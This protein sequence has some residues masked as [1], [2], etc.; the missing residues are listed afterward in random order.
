MRLAVLA[1]AGEKEDDKFAAT[2]S[3]ACRRSK[4]KPVVGKMKTRRQARLQMQN[5]TRQKIGHDPTAKTER[6]VDLPGEPQ[7]VLG[8]YFQV[9]HIRAGKARATE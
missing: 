6:N 9:P 4:Q 7:G 5:T 8:S 2:S 1:N 3:T